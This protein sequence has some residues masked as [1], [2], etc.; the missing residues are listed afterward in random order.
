MTFREDKVP[1][2]LEIFRNSR[3]RI[4]SMDGCLHLELMKDP[5]HENILTTYSRWES[6]IALNAYRNSALFGDVWPATK[7]LFKEKPVA[8]SLLESGPV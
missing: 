2:F 3:E 6:E 7:A 1:D 4:R 5:E 8:F